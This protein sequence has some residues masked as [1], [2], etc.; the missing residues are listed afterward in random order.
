[1]V[2]DCRYSL[3]AWYPTYQCPRHG[4]CWSE[5]FY[6]LTSL[7][8]GDGQQ[9]QA[10]A[11]LLAVCVLVAGSAVVVYAATYTPPFINTLT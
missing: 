5:L 6:P 8:V 7:S 2:C 1:M 10:L 9:Q 3:A 11:V 4:P